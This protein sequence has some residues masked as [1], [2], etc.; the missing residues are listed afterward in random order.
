[1]L[2]TVGQTPAKAA[3]NSLFSAKT[4][5]AAGASPSQK[6]LADRLSQTG[7]G[8]FSESQSESEDLLSQYK[9]TRKF[10]YGA[11]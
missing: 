11:Q 10:S 2:L 4:M 8:S 6:T 3:C 5:F 7:K 1:M 9:F